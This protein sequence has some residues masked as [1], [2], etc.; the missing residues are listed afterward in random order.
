MGKWR[1][2]KG[3]WNPW[4]RDGKR[5]AIVRQGQVWTVDPDG[6]ATQATFDAKNK[7]FPT[8]SPDGRMVAY[9]TWQ[10][11]TR[12]HYTRLGPTDIWVVDLKTGLAARVTR[13]D[14]GRIESLDWL[15]NG[16]LIFDRHPPGGR[17]SSLRTIS[18]R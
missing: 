11:D 18:L 14:A 8:F 12:E 4:S 16:T 3:R 7:V 2:R 13:A 6:N 10:S 17:E 15:D 5:M 9:I 1:Y